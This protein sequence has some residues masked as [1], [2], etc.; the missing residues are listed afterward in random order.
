MKP[1]PFP[2]I[3][4]PCPDMRAVLGSLDG[5]R[6]RVESARLFLSLGSYERA[7]RELVESLRFINRAID[8]DTTSASRTP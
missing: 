5:A 7:D 3:P 8:R 6:K 4:P 2:D 1:L